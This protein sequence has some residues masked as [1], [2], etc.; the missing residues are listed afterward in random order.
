MLPPQAVR[1]FSHSSLGKQR[2]CKAVHLPRKRRKSYQ[3]WL[4]LGGLS[5][6]V[7]SA[8]AK[9]EAALQLVQPLQRAPVGHV[10]AQH[11]AR[12]LP[13]YLGEKVVMHNASHG[14]GLEA[15][16]WA[17]RSGK[18]EQ[19][20]LLMS[21]EWLTHQE[22]LPLSTPSARNWLPVQLVLQGSWCLLA[23]AQYNLPDFPALHAWLRTLGRPVR[24][25]VPYNFGPP[26]LWMRAMAHKT[27]L[28]WQA[29]AMDTAQQSIAALVAGEVDLAL[30]RCGDMAPHSSP[31]VALQREAR[32]GTQVL[33]RVGASAASVVHVASFRQWQ[34]PPLTPGWIAWFVSDDMSTA[35]RAALG[36]ALNAVLLRDDT[37]SLIAAQQQQPVRM[38]VADSQAY[39]RRSQ[40]QGQSLQ[41]WL[42][43][44]AEPV[45]DVKARQH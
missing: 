5:L 6:W 16:N 10:V 14:K 19:T 11:F 37:Q 32:Y 42:E 35:R 24:L 18:P 1:P 15:I 3:M 8:M 41:L 12:W 20:I 9:P 26:Q 45:L 4:V 7:G 38:S 27:D 31:P 33:A 36:S 17:V 39:V 44:L 34:L 22:L 43:R 21:Q 40:Q 28:P 25:S 30:S 29:K 13:H 23:S 2:A